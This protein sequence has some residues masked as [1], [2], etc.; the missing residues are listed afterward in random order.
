MRKPPPNALDLP[1]HER[2]LMALETAVEKVMEEH[3]LEGLPVYILRD[4]EVIEKSAEEL[5]FIVNPRG[6]ISVGQA[7]EAAEQVG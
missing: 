5:E 4:G 6:C 3:A 7:S 2:A 1:L